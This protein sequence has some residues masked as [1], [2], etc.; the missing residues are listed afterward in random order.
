MEV[1]DAMNDRQE[2]A[3]GISHELTVEQGSLRLAQ[4]IHAVAI[5][6]V[7]LLGLVAAI[8]LAMHIGVSALDMGLLLSMFVMTSLGITV[9]YHRHFSHRA[10]KAVTPLR[11]VLGILGS[12]AGQ[13]S[14]SYWVSNHRRHHQYTDRPGD[15]HSPYIRDDQPIERFW[16]GFW[17]SHMGWTFGHRLTNP[18]RYAKDIYRERAVVF[19]NQTYLLWVLLGLLVPGVIGGLVTD[20]WMGALTGFLWGGLVRMFFTYHTTNAIDSVTHLF[21]SQSYSTGDH[22]RNNIWIVLPTMG[23]G[24]HNNHHACPSAA[25]FARRWWE[26]D[27]GG[28]V[29][30]GMAALGWV[31]DI[32]R[33]PAH[34]AIDASAAPPSN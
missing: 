5:V 33:A 30:R 2:G 29:I 7:P 21:G 13:G 17:H 20:S 23:E 15:V 10:F 24:W 4:K 22:S 11:V 34:G 32:K 3:S 8:T 28:L 1:G 18:L 26:F 12:M 25:L 14:V 27:P 19:V 31:W 16:Q 6:V 9:G